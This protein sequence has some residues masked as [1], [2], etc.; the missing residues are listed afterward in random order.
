MHGSKSWINAIQLSED[1]WRILGGVDPE[2]MP[3]VIPNARGVV[4]GNWE[5]VLGHPRMR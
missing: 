5:R 1:L 4:R 2:N 3:E